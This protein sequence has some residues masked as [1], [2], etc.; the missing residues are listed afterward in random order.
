MSNMSKAPAAWAYQ[1]A[2]T[3]F[4]SYVVNHFMEGF[5]TSLASL[6]PSSGFDSTTMLVTSEFARQDDF[7]ADMANMGGWRT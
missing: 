5:A 7:A 3:I 2:S 4:T 6:A 1:F